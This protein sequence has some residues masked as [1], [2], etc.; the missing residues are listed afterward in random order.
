MIKR[1]KRRL[2]MWLWGYF[3]HQ[4]KQWTY[5]CVDFYNRPIAKSTY[6][7]FFI[8]FVVDVEVVLRLSKVVPL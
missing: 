4:N 1:I 5:H 3:S 8:F 7:K 6:M 2:W